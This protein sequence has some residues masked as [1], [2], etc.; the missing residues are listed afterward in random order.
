MIVLPA[1]DLYNKQVV[2][3]KKGDFNQVTVYSDDPVSIAKSFLDA[4]AKYIHIVDLNA[5]KDGSNINDEVIK[6]IV[7]NVDVDIEVGGGIRTLKRV[8]ELVNLGVS[9]IIVSTMVINSKDVFEEACR[10]YGNKIAV[11]LD[12]VDDYVAIKGWQEVSN[13]TIWD[14]IEY[15][16]PLGCDTVVS[17]DI[18]RDGMMSGINT[19]FY[20]RLVSTGLK[21]IV[22]GGISSNSD[23]EDAASCKPYGMI[24]GRAIYDKAIDIKEVIKCYQEE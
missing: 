10:L 23:C 20:K 18:S 19:D 8:T 21:I 15:I 1:I 14:I 11:S 4:G 5:S 6:D 13:E 22:S 12:V 24:T 9:R 7:N 17:T 2:R 3:L 16:K